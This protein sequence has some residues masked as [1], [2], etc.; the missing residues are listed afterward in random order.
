MRPPKRR[1]QI[2]VLTGQPDEPF[3]LRWSDEPATFD[4][5]ASAAKYRASA[6]HHLGFGHPVDPS[7]SI[8]SGSALWLIRESFERVFANDVHIRTEARSR[9]RPA[10]IRLIDQSAQAVQQIHLKS[11]RSIWGDADRLSRIQT[12]SAR[13]PQDGERASVLV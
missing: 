11:Y 5:C 3:A 8:A 4:A 10:V 2:I 9:H 6:P 1:A 7:G 12:S 13:R